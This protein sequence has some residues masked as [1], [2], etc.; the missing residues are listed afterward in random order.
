[1][2]LKACFSVF[3]DVLMVLNCER[4]METWITGTLLGPATSVLLC[5]LLLSCDPKLSQIFSQLVMGLM[6]QNYV[7]RQTFTSCVANFFQGLHTI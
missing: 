3:S 4:A 5:P 2:V 1:M 7:L 6:L